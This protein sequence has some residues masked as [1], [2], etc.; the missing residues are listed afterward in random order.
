MS[1][2]KEIRPSLTISE[3]SLRPFTYFILQKE[4]WKNH[5]LIF[6]EKEVIQSSIT[7]VYPWKIPL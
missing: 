3:I 4:F 5:A 1:D 2:F 7:S 6:G